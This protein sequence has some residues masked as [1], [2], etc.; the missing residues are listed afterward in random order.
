VAH[1]LPIESYDA[2][3]F[4]SCCAGFSLLF[5]FFGFHFN[6]WSLRGIY[7]LFRN[8]AL[9]WA[10]LRLRCRTISAVNWAVLRLRFR[11]ISTLNYGHGLCQ[12]QA[13]NIFFGYYFLQCYQWTWP[14]GSRT[15]CSYARSIWKGA[16]LLK[17]AW[18]ATR[19]STWNC[20][21]CSASFD[22]SSSSASCASA[23]W[24]RSIRFGNILHS[25]SI[26]GHVTRICSTSDQKKDTTQEYVLILTN[27]RTEIGN[28]LHFW[29]I[30]G[31][32]TGICSNSD[33]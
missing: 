14:F 29:P 1:V 16:R 10:V 4:C 18:A 24:C 20:S 32:N 5:P 13:C 7:G 31:H 26:E 15:I 8:S 19:A 11:T 21:K 33:Q 25:Y 17:G 22:W 6:E 9:N 30:E 3:C 12:S 23:D 27:R 2:T 28:L